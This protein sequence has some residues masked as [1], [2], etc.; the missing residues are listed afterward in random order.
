MHIQCTYRTRIQ[1]ELL[2]TCFSLGLQPSRPMTD[3][4]MV[5]RLPYLAFVLGPCSLELLCVSPGL[6][7]KFVSRYWEG[8]RM[9]YTSTH[10]EWQ[11]PDYGLAVRRK[12]SCSHRFVDVIY[13]VAR[14]S[15]RCKHSIYVLHVWTCVR[16]IALLWSLDVCTWHLHFDTW[17]YLHVPLISLIFRP[18]LQPLQSW[19]LRHCSNT[20]FTT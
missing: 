9:F 18:P 8:P 20:W 19:T 15:N 7:C 11:R 3:Y 10:T 13:S 14:V 16:R 1:V 6:S 17:K 12:I 2:C 5:S 4:M